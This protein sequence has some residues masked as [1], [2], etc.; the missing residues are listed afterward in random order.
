MGVGWHWLVIPYAAS[1]N[2]LED[3]VFFSI[4]SSL[5]VFSNSTLYCQKLFVGG[6]ESDYHLLVQSSRDKLFIM[7][8]FIDIFTGSIAVDIS[9]VLAVSFKNPIVETHKDSRSPS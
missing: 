6:E 9:T 1:E 2:F 5:A 3:E 8:L 7:L 4:E